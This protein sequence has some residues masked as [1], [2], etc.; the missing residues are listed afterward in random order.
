MPGSGTSVAALG[1]G[2]AGR[3]CGRWSS[4]CCRTGNACQFAWLPSELD[5][6]IELGGWEIRRN[7]VSLSIFDLDWTLL[8]AS[9]ASA[10]GDTTSSAEPTAES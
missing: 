8:A 2:P 10:T 9:D 7:D 4:S 3:C 6:E 5:D 1:F